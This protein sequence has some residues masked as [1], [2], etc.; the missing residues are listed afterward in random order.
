TRSISGYSGSPV[1]VYK[2]QQE[3][4][5]I[6]PSP[7][8]PYAGETYVTSITDPVGVPLLLG[9]DCGHVRNKE[10]ILD[11]NGNPHPFGWHVETNTGMA[12]VIPAW[13]LEDLLN[14]PELVM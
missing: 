6:P 5:A 12:I 13:R 1:F 7:L 9:I 11:A 4:K 10:P 3:I 8:D 2:P 14:R